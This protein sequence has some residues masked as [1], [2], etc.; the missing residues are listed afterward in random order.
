M[1]YKIMFEIQCPFDA[2]GILPAMESE[3]CCSVVPGKSPVFSVPNVCDRCNDTN[4]EQCQQ[5][6]GAIYQMFRQGLIFY[7]SPEKF[8]H[9]KQEHW[10]EYKF[11]VF[12][13][14]PESDL[15]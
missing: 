11:Q 5:C 4:F 13:I 8:H 12:P 14:T 3:I 1:L 10:K 2:L 9:C 7:M 6:T 15:L